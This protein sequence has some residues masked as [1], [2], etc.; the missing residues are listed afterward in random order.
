MARCVMRVL[1]FL[2]V[3]YGVLMAQEALPKWSQVKFRDGTVSENVRIEKVEGIKVYYWD[4]NTKMVRYWDE[5]LEPQK[6]VVRRMK[7]AWEAE[8]PARLEAERKKRELR[9]S[10]PS[11]A[12]RDAL[13]A[14]IEGG[15]TTQ[16]VWTMFVKGVRYE[17]GH[18]ESET[19]VSVKVVHKTGIATFSLSD[20]SADDQAYFGYEPA[21]AAR[22]PTLSAAEKAREQAAWFERRRLKQEDQAKATG[23]E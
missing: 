17:V 5:F 14:R 11:K 23:R 18:V 15:V 8:A 16:K 20:L 12:E 22:W 9:K 21:L 3:F 2:T 4:G 6:S 1:L 10:L 7:E 13:A 19:P